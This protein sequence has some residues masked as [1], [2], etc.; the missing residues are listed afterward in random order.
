MRRLATSAALAF[1]LLPAAGAAAHPGHGAEAVYVDGDAFR[2][3]PPTT[4]VGVDDTVIW[5]WDGALFRNHSVTAE[6][7][8]AEQFDSDPTGLP[9]NSSHPDGSTFSHAFTHKGTFTYYCKVHPSMRGSVEVVEVPD[10][11][12]GPPRLR[13]LKVKAKGKRVRATFRLSE[14]ADVVGRIAER[15]AGRWQSVDSFAQRA[16]PGRNEVRVPTDRVRRGAYRLT[17]IAYDG[18]D[19]RSNEVKA[20]FSLRR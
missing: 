5:F 18:A 16:K 14:R 12:P 10:A 4:T 7:G 9:T 19:R 8:Q 1:A 6:P 11:V 3:T 17:M 13:G 15:K 20:R 2:F